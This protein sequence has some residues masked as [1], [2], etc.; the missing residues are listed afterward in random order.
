MNRSFPRTVFFFT[1]VL[2][3]SVSSLRAQRFS[4]IVVFGDSLSDVGNIA[5]RT[6]DEIGVRY[7]SSFVNYT[8]GRFTNGKDTS[9]KAKKVFGVWHEQLAKTY[10]GIAPA[11]ASEDGGRDYA[12]GGAKTIDGSTDRAL[13][14]DPLFDQKLSIQIDDMGKQVADYLAKS[15]PPADGLFIVWGGGNDL[16]DNPDSATVTQTANNVSGLVTKLAQAGARF[17][18]VPNVP[19]LGLVPNYKD[20]PDK[21]AQ[22]NQASSDYRTLLGTVLDRTEAA[23][24]SQGITITIYRLD[25]FSAFMHFVENPAGW[26]FT[27][28]TDSSQ[29]IAGSASKYLFW[30]GIHPTTVGHAYIAAAAYALI[31]GQSVI[32]ANS[33]VNQVPEAAGAKAEFF[34]TRM[35]EDLSTKIKPFFT[36]S[37]SATTGQ[38]YVALGKNKSK[39]PA[40][41]RYTTIDLDIND[42]TLGEQD[43]TIT[44]TLN[45]SPNFVIG[46]QMG[47][48]TVT[49]M[50][51][52]N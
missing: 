2:A 41:K 29:G 12:F 47:A 26:G 51:N 10:L 7:P 40:N 36:L 25:I 45:P 18:I 19:P 31:S 23:L 9:P 15:L 52:D 32:F 5:S 22:L 27:N 8:D 6:E 35:G 28:I 16:F 43:E 21:A 33:V 44:L 39:L 13:F 1:A 20:N 38:D 50:H 24:A 34:I 48:A 46:G 11:T 42:D 14:S 30:D 49:I 37:G 4:E 3:V 17:F